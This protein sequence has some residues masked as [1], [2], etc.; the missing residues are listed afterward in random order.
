ML[1][2]LS[3]HKLFYIYSNFLAGNYEKARDIQLKGNKLDAVYDGGAFIAK[4]ME[5]LR[6]LGF[7]CGY[8]RSP[9]RRL[10][11]DQAKDFRKACEEI[12][13]PDA[14]ADAW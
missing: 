1:I 9:N 8:G 5:L 13:F 4:N 3:E 11:D 6:M 12:N 14:F 10:T 7:D 2:H